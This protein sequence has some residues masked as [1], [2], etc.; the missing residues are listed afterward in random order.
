MGGGTSYICLL[1]LGKQKFIQGLQQNL[2]AAYQPEMCQRLLLATKNPEKQ[3][4]CFEQT[5]VVRA[6]M[7]DTDVVTTLAPA[8]LFSIQK[9]GTLDANL[10]DFSENY[11]LKQT[12]TTAQTS[13]SACYYVIIAHSQSPR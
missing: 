3:V 2:L 4:F 12:V 7:E 10:Q 5:G 13:I 1:S 9:M 11:I 6:K 8:L